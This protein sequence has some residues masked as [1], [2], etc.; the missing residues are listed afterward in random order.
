MYLKLLTD[1]LTALL[2]RLFSL[3]FVG[4]I[5]SAIWFLLSLAKT[6]PFKKQTLHC[7]PF[8]RCSHILITVR[9]LSYR[10][11][12]FCDAEEH[13][14][15]WEQIWGTTLGQRTNYI[16]V[17]QC[18][19]YFIIIYLQ[20]FRLDYYCSSASVLNIIYFV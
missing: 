16:N 19:R 15:W 20:I 11:W 10:R 3:I 17:F 2:N 4:L 1:Y 8:S 14:Y 9:L 12:W 5:K 7:S 18:E 13:I 6:M